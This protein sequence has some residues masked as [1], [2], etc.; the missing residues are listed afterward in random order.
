MIAAVTAVQRASLQWVVLLLLAACGGSGGGDAGAPEGPA[1]FD[2]LAYVVTECRIESGTV[3]VHQ[4]LRIQRGDGEPST[5]TALDIGPLDAAIEVFFP[6]SLLPPQR[7]DLATACRR[8]GQLRLGSH[9]VFFFY[10]QDVSVSPDGDGVVFEVT[11]RFSPLPSG[12][13]P[14]ERQGLF[15]VNADGSGLRRVSDA[16]TEPSFVLAAAVNI[17]AFAFS[18]D[19]HS[20]VFVDDGPGPN[21]EIVPQVVIVDLRDD[22]RRTLTRLPAGPPATRFPS[23][24]CA[25]FVDDQTVAFSSSA[26]PQGLNPDGEF[27]LFTVETDGSRLAA[28][29]PFQVPG[30]VSPLFAVTGSQG[31]VAVLEVQDD[32]GSGAALEIFFFDERENVLQLTNFGRNDTLNAL[33]DRGGE[34]V[35]FPA[36][37]DPTGGNPSGNCQIFAV[38][39]IGGTARQLTDFGDAPRSSFGCLFSP[40]P[41]CAIA[42]LFQDP[43]N[44]TLVFHSSCDPLGDNPFGNAI[45]AMRTDGSGLRQIT[46]TRGSVVEGGVEIVELPGP[47][48]YRS[49]PGSQPRS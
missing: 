1:P 8:L 39:T 44:G 49:A 7:V 2:T 13:L 26:N 41:G 12:S 30:D 31:G 14:R 46:D 15:F 34:T 43:G 4:D 17:R 11:D 18:P 3:T 21:G 36:S 10:L 32:S 40:L 23:T 29:D 42:S 19:G 38:P 20:V 24:C 5:V 27:I 47:F 25:A 48:G 45:F 28:V 6:S 9:S 33:L 37:A 22:T 35:F 16:R